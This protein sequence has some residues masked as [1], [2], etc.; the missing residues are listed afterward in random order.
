MKHAIRVLERMRNSLSLSA[1]SIYASVSRHTLAI[2]YIYK[3]RCDVSFRASPWKSTQCDLEFKKDVLDLRTKSILVTT[4][5]SL[6]F[7]S[8]NVII[9]NR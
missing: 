1:A 6:L 4:S 8:S 7:C 9:V 5:H 2:I 3:F